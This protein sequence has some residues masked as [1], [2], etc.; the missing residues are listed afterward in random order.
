MRIR[1]NAIVFFS[2]GKEKIGK[3]LEI[4]ILE[5]ERECLLSRFPAIRIGGSLRAEK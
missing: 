5:R 1:Q 2:E 4:Q 3:R